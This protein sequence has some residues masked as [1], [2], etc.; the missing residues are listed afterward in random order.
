MGNSRFYIS[1]VICED[2]AEEETFEDIWGY[3]VGESDISLEGIWYH[4][5]VLFLTFCDME[6][7]SI[8]NTVRFDQKWL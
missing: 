6:D 1:I 5:V 7:Q 2:M 4:F 3:I 8:E